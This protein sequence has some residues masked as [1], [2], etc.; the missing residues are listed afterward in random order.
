MLFFFVLGRKTYESKFSQILN[1][2]NDAENEKRRLK[3]QSQDK[4]NSLRAIKARLVYF[5]ILTVACVIMIG[6]YVYLNNFKI[7]I[8][9]L[10]WTGAVLALL[11]TLVIF[12]IQ[13]LE[14]MNKKI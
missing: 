1:T 12:R 14:I 11:W 13:Y 4:G 10:I 7:N 3:E 8:D 5:K 6:I 2:I 9:Y